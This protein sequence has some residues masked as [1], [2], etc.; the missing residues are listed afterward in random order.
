[1][2]SPL[3]HSSVYST[4]LHCQSPFGR[5]LP[6]LSRR[7]AAANVAAA[8]AAAGRGNAAASAVCVVACVVVLPQ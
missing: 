4:A 6:H 8:V 7:T 2:R 3:L 5:S 1:M